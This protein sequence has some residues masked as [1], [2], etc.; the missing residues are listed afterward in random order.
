M[1]SVP[2]GQSDW[3]RKVADEVTVPVINRYFEKDP[4]NLDE[5]VSLISRPALKR[6][7]SVGTG[8]VRT[9]YS[10]PGSFS[11]ALFVVS[12]QS[13]YKVTAKDKT[14]TSLAGGILGTSL[15]SSPSMAATSRIGTTPEY[16]FMADGR[17][18]SVYSENSS[19]SAT[20]TLN[21]GTLAAGDVVRI[22][23][24]YY[25]FTAGSVDLGA[26]IGT[27]AAP[28]LLQI[29]VTSVL[30]LGNLLEAIGTSGVAGTN[31]STATV[32]HK[33]V[34][35]G[36]GNPTSIRV[37]AITPGAIGNTIV[38]T[39]TSA[40][41]AWSSAT[42]IAGGGASFTQVYTPD[43][44]GIKSVAYIGGFIICVGAQGYGVNGRFY[45]IN[46]GE[47]TIDPL[48]FATAERA[49]DGL[50][51]CR[52]VGD[53]LYLFGTDTTEVWSLTGDSF[54]PFTRI[55]GRSFDHGIIDG[56]DVQIAD[57]LFVVD[58]EGVA[59][60]L[61]LGYYVGPQRVS[62][63]SIEERI[64]RALI[65]SKLNDLTFPPPSTH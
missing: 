43:G 9:I 34:T 44:V 12:G 52:V 3:V 49:P 55:Q 4:T 30:S 51:S 63:N 48:N 22:D 37:A 26:P 50:V 40:A 31:Y 45:W 60:I 14:V 21:A 64:R 19:S 20:L 53:Q 62:D 35:A 6:L 18:L 58:A 42:L 29:G 59:Y 41:A 11:D 8:P 7:L 17:T 57:S 10:Q 16:L 25:Q 32:K 24:V 39:T 1:T 2:I 23:N 13:L 36:S 65:S 47:I 61:G 38:T 27:M 28:W 54:A 15:T 5:Q 56:T 46:P 33:T